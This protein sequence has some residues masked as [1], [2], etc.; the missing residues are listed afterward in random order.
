VEEG[1]PV[2]EEMAHMGN[3]YSIMMD[4]REIG[5]FTALD[6]QVM[7]YKL[8]GQKGSEYLAAFISTAEWGFEGEHD[9]YMHIISEF[10]GDNR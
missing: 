8:M 10:V 9:V 2:S 5:A 4:D 7:G 6:C 1:E 3:G